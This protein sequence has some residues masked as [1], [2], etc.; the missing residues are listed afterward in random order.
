MRRIFLAALSALGAF[1]AVVLPAPMNF[2]SLI[3]CVVGIF[4]LIK[5]EKIPNPEIFIKITP[6]D[7]QILWGVYNG[8]NTI[9]AISKSF[10]M[11]WETARRRINKLR[12]LGLLS[13][14][15]GQ[16]PVF[17]LT[18]EGELVV[19]NLPQHLL[20]GSLKTETP[21]VKGL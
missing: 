20:G 16:Y 6:E 18:P 13:V 3:F 7:A 15:Q 8:K 21:L 5:S 2:I 19:R 1:F 10:G 17:S 12:D 14:N 4:A 9:K 11:G